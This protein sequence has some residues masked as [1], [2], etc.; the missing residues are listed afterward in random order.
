MKQPNSV[1][2]LAAV[3]SSVLLASGFVAYSAGGFGWLGGDRPVTTKPINRPIVGTE[4]FTGSKSGILVD[5]AVSPTTKTVNA[6]PPHVFFGGSKSISVTPL[7][8][9]PPAVTSEPI[10]ADPAQMIML[11]SKSP[12]VRPLISPP[13]PTP[14]SATK[15]RSESPFST[16]K[17]VVQ[18]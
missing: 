8:P 16:S 12:A 7:V 5:P 3:V 11:G 14:D 6:E 17:K 13:A 10:A 15:A 2:K 9:P 1:F 4:T 18:Q